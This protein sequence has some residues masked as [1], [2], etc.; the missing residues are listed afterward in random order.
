MSFENKIIDYNYQTNVYNIFKHTIDTFDYTMLICED[1][2]IENN[3]LYEN[4]YS[5]ALYLDKSKNIDKKTII[6]KKNT[7][8]KNNN[9]YPELLGM[10]D[11]KLNVKY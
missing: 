8:D 7:H 9:T 3:I 1:Y 6:K 5:Y 4:K 10:F 11:E 2:L